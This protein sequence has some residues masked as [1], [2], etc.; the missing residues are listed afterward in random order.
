MKRHKRNIHIVRFNKPKTKIRSDKTTTLGNKIELRYKSHPWHGVQIGDSAPEKI[1]AFI[2]VVSSDTVKYEVD[3]ET[4]YLKIDRPQKFSNIMPA[5]YGFVPRTYCGDE[6]ANYCMQK[7]GM[8]G[9]VGDKDPLDICVL[10]EKE[11]NH[12][13]ILV[14]AIPVG[15]F[16]MIDG[17]EADD[18]ILAVL[19]GDSVYGEMTD[20]SQV[21]EG[22]V[23]RLN[24]YFLTYK[25]YDSS[26]SRK[27]E[28]TDIY[29][30][31]EALEVI[32]RSQIDYETTF[33]GIA[34]D[35]AQEAKSILG[36]TNL[37]E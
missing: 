34:L 3:K 5:L 18:K 32:R 21:P 28:I 19:Q 11:V 15:G 7:S 16:R 13:D 27:V 26:S 10:T 12:G 4:G 29:G 2:E 25:G 20:I 1:T 14:Q 31:D 30:R 35:M 8:T 37:N 33:G 24:H 36:E 23:N 9:I 17:G 22:V 6:V